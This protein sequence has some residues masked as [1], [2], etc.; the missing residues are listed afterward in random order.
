MQQKQNILPGLHN[1]QV[2]AITDNTISH[3][4]DCEKHDIITMQ[5]LMFD[6]VF[7]LRLT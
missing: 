3:N 2:F 1:F 5:N 4:G 7:H 6:A